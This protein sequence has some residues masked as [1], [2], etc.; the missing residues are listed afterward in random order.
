VSV[1]GAGARS[2]TA[3]TIPIAYQGSMV[4]LATLTEDVKHA[5]YT[6][7]F[8]RV[9]VSDA[10]PLSDAES[11]IQARIAA[12]HMDGLA[13][14]TPDR[15]RLATRPTVLL[16]G[17]RSIVAL[18]A[19]YLGQREPP[20]AESGQPRGRVARYAWGRDYHD[21]LKQL[22]RE[23]VE[24]IE[25]IAGRH[26]QAR[27]FVDSSPLA[28]RAV[29]HRAGLG[30][31]G[32]NTMLLL[33][34]AGS[35]AF[36]CELIL[37][38]PLDPDVPV[39]KS[40]GACSRCL[41]VCPTGA[42][43]APGVLDT[44]RCISFLTIELRDRIPR[45]LRPAMG[46]WIFGCDDCQE[47]CPV[48]RKALPA[49]IASLRAYD[50]E[51]AFPRLLPLLALDDAQFRQRYRGTPL[52]RAKSWGLQRNVCVA[53]A[54]AGDP[55]AIAPLRQVVLDAARHPL[56][57]EHAAWALGRFADPHA[58]TALEAALRQEDLPEEVAAEVA[59]S[60]DRAV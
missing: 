18:A 36:L 32:K 52:V 53:L 33:P 13:W 38:L 7:G 4:A 21:V 59:L 37:D 25:R 30:W 46:A 50:D 34:G 12:G 56:V 27:V 15:A 49:Q 14:F 19:S 10:S 42:L 45:A 58:R 5:A 44:P 57:R 40:C 2:P 22:A 24:R 31:F 43:V 48:N 9:G 41:D 26:V 6:L 51:S 28:E 55:A 47:I 11:A 39:G 17:A 54:N 20:P 35:W 16:P 8:D 23:L 3:L 60:L 29:A 1:S